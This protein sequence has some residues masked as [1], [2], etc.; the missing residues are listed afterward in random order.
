VIFFSASSFHLPIHRNL[1]T[2]IFFPPIFRCNPFLSDLLFDTLHSFAE[3]DRGEHGASVAKV[4][5]R[6]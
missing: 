5:E 3:Y 6:L 2:R 1:K 4:V